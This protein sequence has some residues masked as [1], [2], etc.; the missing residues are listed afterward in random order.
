MPQLCHPSLRRCIPRIALVLMLFPSLVAGQGKKH[1]RLFGAV[2]DASTG[3]PLENAVVRFPE[4]RRS[5]R[6]GEMG[7][8]FIDDMPKGIFKMEVRQIGYAPSNAPIMFS[9]EDSLEAIV[10]LEPRVIR[11]GAVIVSDNYVKAPL[12]EFDRRRRGSVGRFLT[13]ADLEQEHDR[14][15]DLLV[16]ARLPGVRAVHDAELGAT[17]LVSTRGVASLSRSVGGTRQNGAPPCQIAVYLDG[18]ALVDGDVSWIR[19]SDLAGV[20]YYTESQVPPPYRGIGAS[21]GAILLWSKW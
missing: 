18:V 4:L 2:A 11:L 6:T 21:C 7:R 1:T 13:E 9:G 3:A 10:M 16:L 8:Y 17:Y 12:Q 20:E 19:A 5:V 15:V 14:P